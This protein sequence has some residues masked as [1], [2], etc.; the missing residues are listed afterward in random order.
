MATGKMFAMK[1]M[2]RKLVKGKKAKSIVESEKKVLELLGDQPS[3]FC[4]SLRY[5][6]SDQSDLFFIMPLLTG[7]DLNFHLQT[8][9][10][11]DET[12]ARFYA[13]Q[14]ALGLGHMH[15]LRIVY[16]DLK[17]EN[18]LLSNEGN[19]AISDLGLAKIMR[20]GRKLK[21][22]A[23]TPGYWAPE[24]IRDEAYGMAAVGFGCVL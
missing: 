8:S 18:I 13:A 1:K 9:G 2:D 24:L 10:A 17:P 23:G 11:F 4:V 20:P 12:R 3:P 14:I 16:R 7:G 22:M 5:S 15:A 6:F 21:G 19:V